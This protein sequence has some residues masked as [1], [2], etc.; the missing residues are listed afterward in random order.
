MTLQELA[1]KSDLAP[2]SISQ[3]ER[4]KTTGSIKALRKITASLGMTV[5]DLFADDEEKAHKVI[6]LDRLATHD[7]GNNASKAL[8]TPRFFNHMEVFVGNLGPGGNT[9]REPH[10]H[11][12]SEELILVSEGEVDVTIGE[13]VFQ[14]TKN[15]SI[16]FTSNK[17]HKVQ[18][19]AGEPAV[20][21][22]IIAPP[23]V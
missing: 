7:Y 14:L 1:E 15:Q 3:L 21:M 18:E 22:W 11:G 20:I 9:G 8:V 19:T 16:A 6:S 4:G 12:V 5:S 10:S 2:S 13:E 23:S 17:P